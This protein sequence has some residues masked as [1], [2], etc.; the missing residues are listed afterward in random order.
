MK[1]FGFIYT[2]TNKKDGKIYVGQTTNKPN[3]RWNQ[4]KSSAKRENR[5]SVIYRA[6]AKHGI[7]NFVFEVICSV[8]KEDH[9]DS[10]EFFFMDKFNSIVPNGYNL[11]YFKSAQKHHSEE[12][13]RKIGDA[14]RG[15]KISEE[16]RLKLSLSHM[17]QKRVFSEE[18][19]RKLSLFQKGKRRGPLPLETRLRISKALKGKKHAS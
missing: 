18:H 15:R 4:H 10:L 8:L 12:T 7:E 1:Q 6:M 3:R 11:D 13:K 2:I 19:R 5:T 16:T 9:M 14:N 17:G